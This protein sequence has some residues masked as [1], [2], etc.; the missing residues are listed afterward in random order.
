MKSKILEWLAIVLILETGLLHFLSA[1]GWYVESPLVGYLFIANFLA[2]LLAAYGVFRRQVWGWGLGL[3]VVLGSIAGYTWSRTIGLPGLAVEEWFNPIGLVALSIEIIFCLLMM[4]RPW[5]IIA[6]QDGGNSVPVLF[7]DALPAAGL[8]VISLICF[9]A[10]QWSSAAAAARI[11]KADG[12]VHVGTVGE[13]CRTPYTTLKQ[14]E[15]Q[16]GIQ[17]S[18]VALTTMDTIVNVRLKI[19]DPVKAHDLL[20]NQ[21]AVL[22]DQKSLIVSPHLH[23]HWKLRIDKMYFM[24]FPAQSHTI[25]S[26]SELSLVFGG[27]RVEPIKVQ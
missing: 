20:I 22:I 19:I 15:D 21:A 14:L 12:H 25:K 10:T 1:Q 16:Y 26:G 2:C 27:L 9:G 5:R 24:F 8:V 23:T 18:L 17:V 7:R 4:T 6:A 3:M 13:L 11:D